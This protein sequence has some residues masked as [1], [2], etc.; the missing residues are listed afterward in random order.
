MITTL[1]LEAVLLLL[2]VAHCLHLAADAGEPKY[3]ADN[4]LQ[5]LDARQQRFEADVKDIRAQIDELNRTLSNS[6][7]TPEQRLSTLSE[8]IADER[9][10]LY[11]IE[12]YLYEPFE[13]EPCR[14]VNLTEQQRAT[15][16][17]QIEA[18]NRSLGNLSARAEFC[19]ECPQI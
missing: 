2:G 12:T 14:Q 16:Q 5:D 3:D 4:Y 10:T 19:P 6:T 17:N 8:G 15:L 13:I 7:L 18:V 11:N 9:D 1:K